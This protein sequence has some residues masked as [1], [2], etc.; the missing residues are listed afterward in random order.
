MG[1]TSVLRRALVAIVPCCLFAPAAPAGEWPTWRGGVDRN[2][3]SREQ[4]LPTAVAV[5]RETAPLKSSAPPATGPV[6][7]VAPRWTARLGAIT[8]ASPVV[9]GGRVF[10]GTSAPTPHRPGQAPGGG[11]LLC[12]DER[13]GNLLWQLSLP[14]CSVDRGR[15]FNFDHLRAGVCSTPAVEGN[16]LYFV[17]NRAEILCLDVEGMANGND[18]PFRDE[19]KLLA[20][21]R[22][23]A[24]ANGVDADVIWG[25]DM[26]AGREIDCWPQD[27]ASSSPL[28]RGE[29]IY[30]CP[31]N[32][33]DK[34]HRK[35][36]R[37]DC[38]S[39][40]MLDKRTGEV[41][42]RDEAKIGPRILHG[43]WSSP[44]M[45]RVGGRDLIFHGGGDGV[46]YAFAADATAPAAGGKLGTLKTVWRFDL[47]AAAGLKGK[48][49]TPEGP[50]EIIAT[51]VFAGGRVYAA[52]GQDAG[53]GRGKGALA[54]IDPSGSGDITGSG[55]VWINTDIHRSQST[56]VVAG[57][58][59][60][61]ADVGG[62][63]FCLDAA[64]GKQC[65]MQDTKQAIWSSPLVADGKVYV[66]TERG[67]LW[68]LSAGRE[69]NM[70][71]VSK[72]GANLSA[73]PAAANGTLFIA[74]KSRLWAFGA[75]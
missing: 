16:R 60:Y 34:S 68:V 22:P 73:S 11:A 25:V 45:G 70:L 40:V 8:Y 5:E 38:P 75:N 53:H 36:Q 58:L 21:S 19:A 49:N 15:E 39:M 37:P 74:A 13:T 43:E 6:G 65:W 23:S 27:A 59:V 52:L 72:L 17:S 24:D 4:G 67:D 32:G 63:V 54:C 12:L 62:R 55:Q 10:V 42:A 44:A 50:S 28:I 41:L 51:P 64:T 47:N 56:C 2:G 31:G 71:A 46:C 66:G 48:Y 29:H 30:V 3:A 69:L 14:K 20:T 9:A 33:V 26:L 18:G 7:A 61:T 1:T 35:I 57:G